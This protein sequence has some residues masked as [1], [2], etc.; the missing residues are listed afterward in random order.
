MVHSSCTHGRLP[1]KRLLAETGSRSHTNTF[2]KQ[3]WIRDL[4]KL[5]QMHQRKK[6]TGR[7]NSVIGIGCVLSSPYWKS[8]SGFSSSYPPAP[9]RPNPGTNS[10]NNS[11]WLRGKSQQS[12]WVR[13]R[14]INH[15]SKSLLPPP[16]LL[17]LS[18]K[19]ERKKRRGWKN[20]LDQLQTSRSTGWMKSFGEKT[21]NNEDCKDNG[22]MAPRASLFHSTVL[23]CTVVMI[24]NNPPKF[25]T[26]F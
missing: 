15:W 5:R 26:C 11:L 21:P 14:F 12:T 23:L 1:R 7:L 18:R 3:E 24:L 8:L 9:C 17:F 4:S 13:E 6:K 16:F 20:A 10:V 2:E 25:S 22:K 19:K